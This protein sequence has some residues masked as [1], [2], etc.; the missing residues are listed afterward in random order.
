MFEVLTT[1]TIKL[2]GCDTIH[3]VQKLL[4]QRHFK[5]VVFTNTID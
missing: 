1:V 4:E 3:F 2:L 5:E